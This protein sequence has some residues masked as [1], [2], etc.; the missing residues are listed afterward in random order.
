MRARI[1]RR[2]R[3]RRAL[4]ITAVVVVAFVVVVGVYVVANL[5]SQNPL[6]G[7][8]DTSAKNQSLYGIA[9]SASYGPTSPSLAGSSYVQIPGGTSWYVGSK[10]IVVYIGAEYC[11]YCAFA[12][13]P[14]IVALMR[15]GNFTGLQYTQSSSTDVYANTD[16]FSF[17]GSTYTSNYV[18]FEP[19]EHETRIQGDILESI[20]SN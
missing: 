11:P 2:E 8:P 20:P 13:W 1:R 19:I 14:L 16:T 3:R 4:Y 18:V 5:T 10:P 9:T 12:R 6:I 7:T 17:V 15:F